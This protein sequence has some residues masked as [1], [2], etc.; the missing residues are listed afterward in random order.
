MTVAHVLPASKRS[1]HSF[2][3]LMTESALSIQLLNVKKRDSLG[4]R[5]NHFYSAFV[6]INVGARNR[7]R[8]FV[9]ET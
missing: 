5:S 1:G 8:R 4:A 9:R 3:D 6:Q 2:R 7:P